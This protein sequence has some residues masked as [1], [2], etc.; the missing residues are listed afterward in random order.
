ML[1][2]HPL[3]HLSILYTDFTTKIEQL[4]LAGPLGDLCKPS[5]VTEKFHSLLLLLP[6]RSVL[7]PFAEFL[8]IIEQCHGEGEEAWMSTVFAEQAFSLDSFF[9]CLSYSSE[10]DMWVRTMAQQLG[11]LTALTKDLGSVP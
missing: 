7:Y 1:S 8:G 3:Q 4:H 10:L 9:P 6:A 11:T 5:F 2:L